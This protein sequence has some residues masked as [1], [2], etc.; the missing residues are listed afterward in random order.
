MT[1]SHGTWLI[2]IIHMW[3]DDF[4]SIPKYLGG[5]FFSSDTWHDSFTWDMTHSYYSY[6]TWL[7]HMG[8]DSFTHDMTHSHGTWL[9]YIIHMWH[10]HFISIPKYLGGVFFSSDTWH[11]SFTWDMTH[12]HGTWLIHM[13]HDSF[14]W[15]LT[16]SHGT[17][18][19]FCSSR[20]RS[21]LEAGF[22]PLCPPFVYFVP[23]SRTK[24][25]FWISTR[26]APGPISQVLPGC[27]VRHPQY[28]KKLFVR[29]RCERYLFCRS[30]S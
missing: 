7:I 26:T 12:S 13:G 18:R 21:F 27:R 23:L 6:V 28:S 29:Y 5:I 24:P 4:I 19:V 17:W 22:G 10:D 9:I 3:H 15:D 20:P 16:H 8:H 14:T 2:H 25:A 30:W 11:D 1:H